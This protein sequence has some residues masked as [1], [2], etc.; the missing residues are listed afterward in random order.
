MQQA[1]L[2]A[3]DEGLGACLVPFDEGAAQ[4]YFA[5]PET[6]EAIAAMPMARTQSM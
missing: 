1:Y 2:A 5:V 3:V 4:R 6:L